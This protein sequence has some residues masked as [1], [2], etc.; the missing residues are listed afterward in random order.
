MSKAE[1]Y[2][3]TLIDILSDIKQT[4]EFNYEN[5]NDLDK[6]TQDLEHEIE[7]SNFDSKKGYKLVKEFKRVR[8]ERR[9][10]C[11]ENLTLKFLYDYFAKYPNMVTDLQKSRG[12]IKRKTEELSNRFYTPK[13]RTDLTIPTKPVVVDIKPKQLTKN[14]IREALRRSAR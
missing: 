3:N 13:I 14:Q 6:E 9:K 5:V 4:Y 2:V 11:D 12:E 10:L 1:Q 8:Q 7:L